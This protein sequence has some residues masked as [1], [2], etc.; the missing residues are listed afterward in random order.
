MDG[1][2]HLI[3]FSGKTTDTEI[4]PDNT[5]D[6]VSFV[7]LIEPGNIYRWTKIF[8]RSKDALV[9]TRF[10]ENGNYVAVMNDRSLMWFAVIRVSDGAVKT[11][12]IAG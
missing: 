3:A 5:A 2:D 1:Y 8:E 12:K 6:G 9:T 11:T 4:Y 7:A 10:S